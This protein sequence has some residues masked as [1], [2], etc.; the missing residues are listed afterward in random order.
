MVVNQHN[1]D[2]CSF[3]MRPRRFWDMYNREAGGSRR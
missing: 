3:G 1:D 2:T